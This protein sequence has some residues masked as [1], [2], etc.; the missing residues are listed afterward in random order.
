MVLRF[1]C[2]P[3]RDSSERPPGRPTIPTWLAES[4]AF[5]EALRKSWV[6]VASEGPFRALARFKGAL[7]T[8]ARAARGVRI[9]ASSAH[10]QLSQL[11]TES[12]R[13]RPLGPDLT[14]VGGGESRLTLGS[15]NGQ[16]IRAGPKRGELGP[17]L[18]KGPDRTDAGFLLPSLLASLRPL[19]RVLQRSWS[20]LLC[21]RWGC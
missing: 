5:G 10:L 15:D 8:A 12:G 6:H 20:L 1:L 21:G 3:F 4:P 14:P 16:A 18:G 7:F 11:G 17:E 13:R 19:R 9:A 2:L